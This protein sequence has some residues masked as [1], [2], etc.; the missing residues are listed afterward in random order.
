MLRHDKW[1]RV[2]A[3][4]LDRAEGWFAGYGDALVALGARVV[5]FAHSVVSI[6]A[7]TSRAPPVRFDVLTALGGL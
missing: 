5:T 1:L 6:P 7:G 3:E 2:S 4:G